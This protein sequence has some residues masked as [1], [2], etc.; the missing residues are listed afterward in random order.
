MSHGNPFSFSSKDHEA[1]RAVPAGV[2]CCSFV[3]AGVF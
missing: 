2:G 1:R 3:S